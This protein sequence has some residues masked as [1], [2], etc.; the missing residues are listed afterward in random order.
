MTVLF[1]LPLMPFSLMKYPVVML[2]KKKIFFFFLNSATQNI[3]K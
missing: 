3:N 2:L 1:P